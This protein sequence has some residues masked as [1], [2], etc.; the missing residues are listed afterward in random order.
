MN[1]RIQVE[2]PVTEMITGID[3]VRE[4][5]RIAAG[6]RWPTAR[7]D[8]RMTGHAIEVRINAEDPA[9]NFCRSPGTVTASLR[10]PGGR[11][12]A[13]IRC[14][15]KG[16]Q[17]PPFYDS[18]LGKLIVWDETREAAI[19]RMRPRAGGA[20]LEVGGT[21][22]KPLHQDLLAA[23]PT[24]RKAAISIHAGSS[25]ARAGTLDAESMMEGPSPMKT[26]YSY[27][28][29]EHIFVECDEEMSLEAFFK[30]LS[31]T[32]AVKKARHQGR[33]RNLPGQRLLPDQVRSRRDQ[34]GRHAEGD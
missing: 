13:S 31:M 19:H 21:T 1:T 23:D 9:E 8:V 2:H 5:I 14:S 26:R 29:D 12:R 7:I 20:E 32:N 24:V 3:L 4:M 27:G 11:A 18:L 30:S 33:H 15:I 25:L 6:S 16:Y 28:G 17:V 10:V 34:A 22:T